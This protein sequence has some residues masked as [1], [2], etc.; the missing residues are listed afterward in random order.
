[1]TRLKEA[2]KEAAKWENVRPGGVPPGIVCDIDG[3]SWDITD[4]INPVLRALLAELKEAQEK[5]GA[6]EGL[7]ANLAQRL[8]E[9]KGRKV[10]LNGMTQEQ[11]AAIFAIKTI[12]S[13]GVRHYEAYLDRIL[14][15][16]E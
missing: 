15:G 14:E 5:L 12:V 11:K 8:K 13:D 2:R 9:A 4:E 7:A 6:V 16:G 1:M 10:Q 3:E